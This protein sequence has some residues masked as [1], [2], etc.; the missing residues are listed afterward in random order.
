MLPAPNLMR[1]TGSSVP[2]IILF[3]PNPLT[4]AEAL[5]LYTLNACKSTFDE[6]ERGSLERGKTADMVILS[7]NPQSL[8]QEKLDC[9]SVEKTILKGRV[10][11][12]HNY[13]VPLTLLRGLISS[14]KV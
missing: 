5:K 9:L 14:E 8:P 3:L 2:V 1:S 11:P 4:V 12:A 7:D 10:N 13:S 6:K